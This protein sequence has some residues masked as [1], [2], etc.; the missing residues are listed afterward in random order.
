MKTCPTYTAHIHIAGDIRQAR[1]WL[2]KNF[3]EKGLCVTVI[4][5]WFV[6]TGGEEKGMKISLRNYPRFPSTPD[7]ITARAKVIAEAL[8]V[9]LCQRTALVEGPVDSDW[10]SIEPPGARA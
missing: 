6:Y 8:V 5:Q 10:I 7:A 3:Y 4:R 1:Q 9:E 2:R